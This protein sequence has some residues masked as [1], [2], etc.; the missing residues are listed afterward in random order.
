[1]AKQIL[2]NAKLYLD[3]Y[4]LSGDA[5]ALALDYGADLV[6]LTTINQTTRVRAPGLKQFAANHAGFWSGG[7]DLVDEVLFARVGGAGVVSTIC[8]TT[9]AVGEPCLFGQM[10][11]A[12][13]VPGGAVGEA[14]QFT[15]AMESAS[16]LYRGTVL[17][18]SAQ[19]ATG[20]S[21][22]QNLGAVSSTQKLCAVLHV[23]D[24]VVG[25]SIAVTIQ[26]A[27]LVGFG[28]PTTR[29]TFATKTAK[30]A[31]LAVAIPGPITDAFW[32][33]SYTVVG[34]GASFPIVVALAIN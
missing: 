31:E 6:D 11:V 17:V 9:G 7:T 8:P 20:S 32:R 34:A 33:A 24:P 22:V 2:S 15:V 3:G 18:N 1:M 29:I 21:A 27:A 26:S 25:T 13:Y 12:S 14:L 4:D 5:S 28:A 16:D 30:G 23:T 19:G 10:D